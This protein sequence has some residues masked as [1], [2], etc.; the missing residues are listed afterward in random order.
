MADTDIIS[1]PADA[2]WLWH[3]P[4]AA[5]ED[6]HCLGWQDPPLA[7]AAEAKALAGALA[8]RIGQAPTVYTSDLQRARQAARPLA[9]ALGARLVVTKA[10]R[11]ASFGRWEGRPWAAIQREEPE[12]YAHYMA[13]WA[14]SAMPGGEAWRDVQARVARWWA[15]EGAEGPP[16]PV[17]VVGHGSSLRALA[18][19]LYGWTPQEAIAMHLARAHLAVLDRRRERPPHWNVH[20][21]SP[22]AR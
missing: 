7:D 18:A 17:V 21:Q 19:H 1:R 8:E 2:V 9:R 6:G 13:H 12:A 20:P 14:T 10:L 16:G 15:G 5:G 11:E 22:M 4:P 3:H